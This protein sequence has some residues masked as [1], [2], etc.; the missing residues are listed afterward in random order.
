MVPNLPGTE[1]GQNGRRGRGYSRENSRGGGGERERGKAGPNL[2]LRGYSRGEQKGG[3]RERER[4]EK[5]GPGPN[6][7][8]NAAQRVLEALDP[9]LHLSAGS[10]AL[11]RAG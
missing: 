3:G 5:R 2:V 4:E 11:L 7:V 6:L 8:L 10:R 1:R 9:G